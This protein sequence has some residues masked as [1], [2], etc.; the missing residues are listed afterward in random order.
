MTLTDGLTA[1]LLFL[2][3]VAWT[4]WPRDKPGSLLVVI[5]LVLFI[6]YTYWP[7]DDKPAVGVSESRKCA[8]A[9]R[10]PTGASHEPADPPN[11]HGVYDMKRLAICKMGETNP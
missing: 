7:R 11:Q 1:I 10:Q 9:S 5:L 2:F 8:S 3:F 4:Y 6:A